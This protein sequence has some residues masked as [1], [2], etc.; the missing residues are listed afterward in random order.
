MT[1]E[2]FYFQTHVVR[3]VRLLHEFRAQPV[4]PLLEVLVRAGAIVTVVMGS[5]CQR[6]TFAFTNAHADEV[7]RVQPLHRWE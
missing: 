4:V 5:V 3:S 6:V 7:E 2:Q 1:Y